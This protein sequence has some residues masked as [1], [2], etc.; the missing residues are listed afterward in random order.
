MKVW[1]ALLI[2]SL[3]YLFEFIARVEPSLAPQ[4]IQSHFH[5]NNSQFGT[6][7]S[8]FFFVYAP[9]QI[10]VGLLVDRYGARRFIVLGALLCGSGTLLFSVTSQPL[11]AAGGR[12]L[13]GFGASFAFVSALYV[14]AHYFSQKW[15][16]ALSGTVNMIGMLGTAI[17]TVLLST[18]IEKSGWQHVFTLAG[19]A[20][21]LIAGCALVLVPTAPQHITQASHRLGMIASIQTVVLDRRIWLISMIGMLYYVPV[22]VYGTLWGNLS[23]QEMQGFTKVQA[24]QAVSLLF[25]GLAVGSIFGGVLSDHLGH[26]KWIVFLGS[27]LASI[28]FGVLIFAPG[29]LSVF[30]ADGLLFLI[31]VFCGPQMLVFAMA[32]ESHDPH[33]TGTVIAFVN[34]INIGGAIVFEPFVGWVADI[35][36]NNFSLA[37]TT[38]PVSLILTTLLVLFLNE[39][40]QPAVLT[41]LGETAV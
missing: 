35:S 9:M 20:G 24:E 34:M 8:L 2:A 21:V 28:A 3:F 4:S 26:R 22:T 41:N 33:I 15:F 25:W 32:K 11:I 19:L 29:I 7:A 14:V 10:T 5:L 12:L 17:G 13:T 23:L 27:I 31:G 36:G 37:L 38:I 30:E 39:K 6:L 16:A 1:F 18:A 40:R